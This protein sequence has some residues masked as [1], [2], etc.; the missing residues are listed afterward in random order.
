M[1]RAKRIRPL[2]TVGDKAIEIEGYGT[3][4]PI[5]ATIPNFSAPANYFGL[6]VPKGVPAEVV[7]TLEKAWGDV[8]GKNEALRKYAASRGAFFGPVSG[9]PAQKAAFPAIQTNA[10][11]LFDTG[12]AKVSPDTVGIPRP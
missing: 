5:S 8:I 2:A 4:P 9:D 1:I 10:W 3:I 6:F 12:K 7:A 11:L